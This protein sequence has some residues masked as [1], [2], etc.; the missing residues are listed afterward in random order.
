MPRPE[1]D[2]ETLVDRNNVETG[3]QVTGLLLVRAEYRAAP[4]LGRS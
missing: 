4:A 1:N 2:P 3:H